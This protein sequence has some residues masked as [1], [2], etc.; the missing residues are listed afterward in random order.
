MNLLN[1]LEKQKTKE[2]AYLGICNTFWEYDSRNKNF[3]HTANQAG[4]INGFVNL[5][6]KSKKK[7]W[8]KKAEE[9]ADF[10]INNMDSLKRFKCA[11][12]DSPGKNSGAIHYVLPDLAL[13]RL[14]KINKKKKYLKAAKENLEFVIK[15]EKIFDYEPTIYVVCNQTAKLIECLLLLYKIE[16]KKTYLDESIK[17]ADWIL[18]QQIK[19]GPAKGALKQ[20]NFDERAF[21]YY[22]AKSI[23]ALIYLY[24]E[25]KVKKYLKTAIEIGHFLEKMQDKTGLFYNNWELAIPFRNPNMGEITAKITKPISFVYKKS[26][27]QFYKKWVLKKKPMWIARSFNIL[28]AMQLLSAYGSF[29]VDFHKLMKYQKKNGS[30]PN[31]VGYGKKRDETSV[32]RWNAYAFEYLTKYHPEEFL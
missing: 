19:K 28:Y 32:T 21:S 27:M 12:G 9:A 23:P 29:K 30:F 22:N 1:W 24:K 2:G 31:T 10:L 26:I 6:K 16:K 25:T 3:P 18:T 11:Y 17:M 13:L 14:Y 5:Y 8:L 7:K 20:S 15:N 4:M